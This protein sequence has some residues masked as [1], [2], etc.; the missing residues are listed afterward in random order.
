MWFNSKKDT[1]ENDTTDNG[2]IRPRTTRIRKTDMRSELGLGANKAA[3]DYVNR[4][5]RVKINADETPELKTI[6]PSAKIDMRDT[7]D[8]E[9][10]LHDAKIRARRQLIGALV[11]LAAAF[12]VLPWVFDDQRKLAAPSVAI[13]VPEKNIQFDVKNPRAEGAVPVSSV[14]VASPA[15]DKAPSKTIEKPVTALV[16]AKPTKPKDADKAV[17]NPVE[18]KSKYVVHIGIVSSTGELSS[19]L[20]RLSSAG[21]KATKETVTVDGVT[22]TRVRLGPF[23]SQ[24]EAQLAADK[25]K[26]AAK[27]PVVIPINP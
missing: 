22:K 7:Y 10:Q 5:S 11:L 8:D 4:T 3:S 21:V 15:A 26:G 18:P 13:T 2:G 14:A 25:A 16:E 9:I 12:V 23:A 6:K 24:T 20:K 1:S 19:L 17:A 27:N